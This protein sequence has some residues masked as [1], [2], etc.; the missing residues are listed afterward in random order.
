[1]GVVKYGLANMQKKTAKPLVIVAVLLALIISLPFVVKLG[2]KDPQSQ[3]T[4]TTGVESA[5][6]KVSPSGAVRSGSPKQMQPPASTVTSPTQPLNPVAFAIAQILTGRPGR[7][8]PSEVRAFMAQIKAAGKAARP[9]IDK[10]F[11]SDETANRVLGIFLL[12]ETEGASKAVL[13]IAARDPALVVRAEAAEW[14][15]RR[16]DFDEWDFYLRDSA[17]R[18]T[19]EEVANLLQLLS[20]NPAT[21]RVSTAMGLL[22]LGEGLPEYFNHLAVH[23]D[24]VLRAAQAALLDPTGADDLRDN[25]FAALAWAHPA[26][27]RDTLRKMIDNPA[28]KPYFR[29]QAMAVYAANSSEKDNDTILYLKNVAERYP[30][31][32]DVTLQYREQK[33]VLAQALQQELGNPSPDT[34][35]ILQNLGTY[36]QWVQ[37]LGRGGNAADLSLLE[38][39]SKFL[40]Q[41]D[42]VV[43]NRNPIFS[44]VDYLLWEKRRGL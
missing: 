29:A 3:E 43:K 4:K 17:S 27:Y 20:R 22:H 44:Q 39:S 8:L 9:E 30:L 13:E 25:V 36:I 1:M 31:T 18:L 28:E 42:A 37:V 11:A 6:A 23:S 21:L 2:K 19:P 34:V 5:S 26:D 33:D 16:M 32:R 35:K 41:Q 7:V 10:L 12:L 38:S 14:L 15:Y 40:K 24:T